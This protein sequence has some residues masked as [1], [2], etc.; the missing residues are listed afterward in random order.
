MT[1]SVYDS[2]VWPQKPIERYWYIGSLIKAI[3]ENIKYPRGLPSS[4]MPLQSMVLV[5]RQLQRPEQGLPDDLRVPKPL[6]YVK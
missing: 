4:L 6:K 2:L 1:K 5:R 3:K